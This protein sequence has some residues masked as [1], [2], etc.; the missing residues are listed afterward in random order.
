M[1]ILALVLPGM[2]DALMFTPT[3]TAL[4]RAYPT[5]EIVALTMLRATATVL[6]GNPDVSRV[7]FVDFLGGPRVA[8]VRA[9]LRYR[10]ERF[11]VS[12][13]AFPS[14]RRPYHVAAGI[15]GARRRVAHRFVQGYWSQAHF[16]NTDLVPAS[17]DLHNVENNLR[18][19]EPLGVAAGDPSRL[20]LVLPRTA[21]DRA[22]AAG[23]LTTRHRDPTR[24]V[25]MH[26]GSIHYRFSPNRRWPVDRFAALARR[27]AT[28]G[29]HSLV[30]EGPSER[31]VGDGIAAG[32][33]GVT[34]V[35]EGIL[36]R[37]AAL[38]ERL[39]AFVSNDSGLLHV[40]A[41][42]GVPT[43]GI[44]AATNPRWTAPWGVPHRT[45]AGEA[46][47]T[48][49]RPFP[50]RPPPTPESAFPPVDAVATALG[51]LL[52]VRL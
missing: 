9:L 11:D 4:K 31:G 42:C 14:Y 2:G 51:E 45:V 26:P 50:L 38:M 12:L 28:A 34:V 36:L 15:V 41:A 10:R 44:Y 1:K 48:L 40:A 43:V 18:L 16:L 3:L 8:S 7:E 49:R 24:C 30:F 21:D 5:A 22:W 23:Y 27:L 25:G 20:R 46:A 47:D 39:A 52:G 17:E 13:T 35:R 33:P 19:L 6:R 29:F 32:N 37:E